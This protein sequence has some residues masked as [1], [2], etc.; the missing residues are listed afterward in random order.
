MGK[1]SLL[2]NIHVPNVKN[3][4]Q[5]SIIEVIYMN[6]NELHY[7]NRIDLMK[8]RNRENKNIINKCERKIRNLGKKNG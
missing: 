6:R 7:Q 2:K 3:N 1:K 4:G 8:G 5:K